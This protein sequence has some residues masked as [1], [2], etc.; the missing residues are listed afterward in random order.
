MEN[1][2]VDV[3]V[4]TDG[5]LAM[6]FIARAEVDEQ[7]PCPQVLLLDLNLPKAEGFEVLKR[8]RTS[9]KCKQIPVLIMTSSDARRDR[10]E[11]ARLGAQYFPNP[12]IT[13][14]L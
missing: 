6:E 9:A 10:C 14:S 8:I 3:H 5:E 1:L 4:V 12:P 7:V 11:A 2:P 13:T